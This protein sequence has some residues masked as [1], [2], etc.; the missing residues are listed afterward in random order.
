MLLCV[1][2]VCKRYRVPGG[3]RLALDRVS[4]EL[5]RGQML[6]V[7]GP[8]GAGK[9]TLLR[10]AA[11]LLAPDSGQVIYAGQ[12]LDEL[13]T[14]E[15]RRLRRREISCLWSAR[16][17]Q[18]RLTALDHV[19]V[20][21]LVDGRDHRRAARAAHEALL[22][23][24]VEQCARIELG[25]LSDGERQR[26]EIARAIV[27]EPKL[28][29]ADSPAS[30]LSLVEQE[31]VMALLHC[32]AREA[33][34]AVLVTDSDAEALIGAEKIVYLSSGRLISSAPIGRQGN[35]YELPRRPRTAAADG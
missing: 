33:R 30:S 35:V 9:S 4:L 8:S 14:G 10:V 11:G 24:E 21:L 28:L 27:T 15:R 20:A 19:A 2:E 25:A 1:R 7:Y 5:D 26:V 12:R 6:G 29:L 13:P 23:C 32:L 18:E 22:A 31:T 34:V 17:S 3:E 16:G